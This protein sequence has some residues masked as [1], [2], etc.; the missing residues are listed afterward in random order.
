[1]SRLVYLHVGLHKTGTTYLQG[2]FAANRDGLRAQGVDYP[3]GEGQ[4]SQVLAAYDLR[5]RRARGHTSA[6]V[7]GS[8]DAL[9]EHIRSSPASKALVSQESLALATLREARRAVASFPDA[10]VHAVVTARDLGRVLV[11]MWQE[12]IKSDATWTWREYVDAVQDPTRAA[13][14]PAFGFWR[15]QDLVRICDTWAAAVGQDRLHLVTVPPAGAPPEELV[16]RMAS[17]VGFDSAPLAETPKRHNEMVGPAGVEVLRQVNERLGGRLN[18]A[19]RA[20]AVKGALVPALERPPPG[21]RPGLR[22]PELTWVAQ[23]AEATIEALRS[24][25]YRVIGDLDDLRPQGEA[26]SRA[27][28]EAT[29]DELYEVA[30]GTVAALTERFA[31]AWW[32][33]RGTD[34]EG[35]VEQGGRASRWRGRMYAMKLQVLELANRSR[36]ASK[37]LALVLRAEDRRLERERRGR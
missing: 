20:R 12:D 6:R 7:A 25:G 23:R 32:L 30:V 3:G 8:W 4:P 18:E 35:E 24:R 36:V 1:M 14:Q 9:T 17:A 27:P 33:R 26:A 21:A 28:D 22:E 19:Q 37:A 29:L 34:V 13:Q 16:R 2:Y 31:T 15:R 5:G 11:S 10:E